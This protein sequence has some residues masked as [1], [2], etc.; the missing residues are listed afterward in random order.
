M[1]SKMGSAGASPSHYHPDWWFEEPGD[2]WGGM[3]TLR[4][5][6]FAGGFVNRESTIKRAPSF[7]LINRKG[8]RRGATATE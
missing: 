8:T 5:G 1:Q 2:S 7:K 6:Q 4:A 3:E